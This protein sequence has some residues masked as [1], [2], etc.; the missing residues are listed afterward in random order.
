LSSRYMPIQ[1]LDVLTMLGFVILIG[2]VVNNAILIVHQTLNFLGGKAAVG[3]DFEGEMTPR[4]AIAEA[5]R[6]RVRPIFM[7]MCTSV[8]GMLPLVLMPGS[9]SELYR[10]LGSVVVG[11]LIVSTVFTLVLVPLLLSLVFDVQ[12]LLSGRV[13]ADTAEELAPAPAGGATIATTTA[14]R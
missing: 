10:G 13:V 5:V 1:K 12:M 3:R 9:G 11:G 8:G 14:R 2:V 6:T 7:S 4:R